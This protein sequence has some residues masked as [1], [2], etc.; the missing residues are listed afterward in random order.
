MKIRAHAIYLSA[1]FLIA[2]SRSFAEAAPTNQFRKVVLAKQLSDPMELSVAPDGRVFFIERSGALKVWK[3]DTQATVVAAR[4]PVTY[5]YNI[6]AEAARTSK[7]G[8][9]EDGLHSIQLD[10]DF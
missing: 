7:A 4:I 9:C 1:F 6:G 5:N 2:C 3:P 10:P 8:G